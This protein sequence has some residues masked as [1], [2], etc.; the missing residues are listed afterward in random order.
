MPSPRGHQV[1]KSGD[2]KSLDWRVILLSWGLCVTVLVPWLLG[3]LLLRDVLFHPA[4]PSVFDKDARTDGAYFLADWLAGCVM[5]LIL[6]GLLVS[7]GSW[8]R[9]LATASVATLTAALSLAILVP[10]S[11]EAWTD[12]EGQTTIA[13]MTSPYPF[14]DHYLTCGSASHE[15]SIEGS[16]HLYQVHSSR[17]SGSGT[18]NG[19][20]VYDGWR[21]VG[22]VYLPPGEALSASSFE[23]FKGTGISDSGVMMQTTANSV[24]GLT[25][26]TPNTFWRVDGVTGIAGVN[27][28]TSVLR[29][30]TGAPDGFLSTLKAVNVKD[31]SPLWEV[32]CPQPGMYIESHPSLLSG[33]TRIEYS[34]YRPGTLDVAD[35]VVDFSGVVG[36]C[37]RYVANCGYPW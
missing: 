22:A 36:T 32:G 13:L 8:R 3:K 26:D 4:T 33:D 15:L 30:A 29:N 34:C 17:N 11:S 6:A 23:P 20:N 27:G 14:S 24:V 21:K 25:L 19:V 10:M 31:G 18:C 9:R 2:R 12:A 1:K 16:S 7:I 37:E 35:F 28:A 5:L